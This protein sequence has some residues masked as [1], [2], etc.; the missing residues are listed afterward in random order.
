MKQHCPVT[1]YTC[2]SLSDSQANTRTVLRTW[3]QSCS[4]NVTMSSL[5]WCKPSLASGLTWACQ[6][7]AVSSVARKINYGQPYPV[8]ILLVRCF[9]FCNCSPHIGP[10]R[11]AESGKVLRILSQHRLGAAGSASSHT[12]S[13]ASGWVDTTSLNSFLTYSFVLST[14]QQDGLAG[15]SR[16]D[17]SV[18]D[19]AYSINLMACVWSPEPPME[20]EDIWKLLP[21]FYLCVCIFTYTYI[22]HTIHTC[23]MHIQ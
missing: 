9:S 8:K 22:L 18:R 3:G 1:S 10:V 12:W 13:S 17:G 19:R 16:Q 15:K 2:L 23:T 21:N 11:N 14:I 5:L 6:G 4:D 20:G 7:L